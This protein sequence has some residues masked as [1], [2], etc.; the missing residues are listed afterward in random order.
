MTRYQIIER[1]LRQVYGE[2]P[3]DDSNITTGLVNQWLNDGIAAAAKRNYA[4][5]IQV[6]GVAYVNNSFYTTFKSLPIASFEQFTYQ[7]T[8]PHIPFGIGKNE[9]ISSLT[10]VGSNGNI[11]YDGVPLSENQVTYYRNMPMIPNKIL[12]YPEGTFAYILT[13]MILNSGGFTARIKMVS[14]GDSTNLNSLLNVPDDYISYIIEYVSKMLIME[15]QQV[16]DIQND[17]QEN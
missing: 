14:G 17:G 1:I 16:K 6:D 13:P 8:L 7:V 2:Q 4:E 9:G 15:R 12:Y 10:V 11:S 3:T 5:S